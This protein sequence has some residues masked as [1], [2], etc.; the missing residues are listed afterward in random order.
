MRATMFSSD[1]GDLPFN[2]PLTNNYAASVDPGSS[3]DSTQG[4]SGGSQWVNT[5]ANRSWVCLSA[6][7][8]AAV[9]VL[10]AQSGSSAFGAQGAQATQDTAATLTAAQ[11]LAGILTSNPSGAVNL[12][13]PLATAIDTAV[14]AVPNNTSF[15]FSVISLAGSTNLPTITTNTG[16][17]LVGAMTFTAVAGNAGRFRARKTGTG[18]WT[19]YRIS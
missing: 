4:Y 5:T 6:A 8:G 15:D 16:W 10:D 2:M 19:L 7:A 11:L 18:A 17:T 13:L 9:W 14:G 1:K 12:Q 3:N